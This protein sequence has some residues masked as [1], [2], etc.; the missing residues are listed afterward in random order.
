MDGIHD[1][2]GKHGFGA[3]LSRSDST[4]FHAEWERR[5]FG[6]SSSLSAAGCFH[7]DEFRHAVERVEPSSYLGDGYYARWLSALELLV[8]EC[9]GRPEAGRVG[10]PTASRVVD[11]A[12]RFGVGQRVRTRNLCKPGHCRLP[13]YARCK[14]GEVVILQGSWVLPDSNAHG[15]G[16]NP[17]HV[18]SV[19]FSGEE[20]WGECAEEGTSVSI[21]LFESYLEAV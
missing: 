17:E 13:A 21:D 20:L 18:Y 1:L 4:V 3:P 12:P 11:S 5:V 6:I 7:T 10:D 14:E 15:E 9:G 16:E 19:R 8:H 2:G